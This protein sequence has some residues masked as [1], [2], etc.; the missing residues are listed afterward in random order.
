[1]S[2]LNSFAGPPQERM[3]PPGGPGEA[4]IG[5]HV[6]SFA[7]PPQERMCPPGGP[8]EARLGNA[9]LAM[10]LRLA[11]TAQ[12]WRLMPHPQM[13]GRRI[14]TLLLLANGHRSL[15]ELSLM[16]GGD[17][18]P[19]ARQLLEQGLLQEAPEHTPAVH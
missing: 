11:R 18:A 17:V 3:Y 1:M 8:G 13:V 9:P 10:Q 7:G 19:L 14:H 4:R 16:L 15:Q 6:L 5:G 2:M 12:A